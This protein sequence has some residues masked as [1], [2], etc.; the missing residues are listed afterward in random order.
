M[1]PKA[2]PLAIWAGLLVLYVVWGSTYL[3]MKLA[4][5][6]MPPLVMGVLRFVPAGLLL[7]LLVA[8]PPSRRDPPA[9]ASARPATPRSSGCC[10][11]WA[12][13]GS[14]AVAEQTI[15][16]GIAAVVIALVPMWLA[17]LGFVFYRR[18]GAAAAGAS[19]IVVGHRRRRDPRVARRRRRR[20]RPGRAR[21]GPRRAG[22]LGGGHPVR[23]EARRAARARAPRERDR[24]D[25][26]RASRFIVVAA[27]TGEWAAFDVAAGLDDELGAASSTSS[28]MG[29]LVGYSTFAW[30]ITVAPLSRVS[31]Y[32]YVNPVVAVILGCARARRAAHAADGRRVGRHRGRGRADRPG[33]DPAHARPGAGG[34][35]RGV[36]ARVPAAGT[37]ESAA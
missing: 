2:S 13:P 11:S 19:G 36:P 27:I 12:A 29:S 5:D 30:L 37:N 23:G 25:W 31:T 35:P 1:R 20:P 16:T 26:P 32:A 3:G 34:R 8:R 28:I 15:P 18:A 24:D 7:I 33:A 10:C 22:V 17:V 4:I 6:T 21:G 9:R 14:S